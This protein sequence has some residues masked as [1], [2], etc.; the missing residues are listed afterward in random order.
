MSAHSANLNWLHLR[1]SFLVANAMLQG[2]DGLCRDLQDAQCMDLE[3]TARDA[4][5]QVELIRDRLRC[6]LENRDVV[7]GVA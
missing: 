1:S 3:A 2:L 4:F 7:A 5:Y 6:R